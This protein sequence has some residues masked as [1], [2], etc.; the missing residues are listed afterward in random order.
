MKSHYLAGEADFADNLEPKCWLI[1]KTIIC[2]FLRNQR[3]ILFF[4]WIIQAIV[5]ANTFLTF[6]GHFNNQVTYIYQI[7]QFT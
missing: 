5:Q 2:V 6:H 7:T 1:K 4:R 3:E